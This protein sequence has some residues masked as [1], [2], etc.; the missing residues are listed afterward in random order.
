MMEILY[1]ALA[2]IVAIGI[3]VTVHEFGHFWVARRVGVRVLRFS[4]GFGR[5]LVRRVGRDGTEYVVAA[6]P[7]GGYVKMLDEREG[8]VPP[9]QLGQTFN[10]KPLWARNAV[11]VAGPMFNFMFAIVAY[12]LVFVAGTMELRPIIGTVPESTPAAAAG[13][14]AGDELISIGG[15]PTPTWQRALM[16]LLDEGVGATALPVTVVTA[17]GERETTTLN[18][19]AAGP[20]GAD[21]DVLGSLGLQPYVPT[22]APVIGEVVA[23]SPAQ[24]AGLASGD[25]ILRVDGE[26]VD[27]WSEAV[28][29]IQSRPGET[30]SIVV[31]RDG[32]QRTLTATLER[33]EAGGQV[34]G[35]LGAGPQI[36]PGLYEDLRRE[37]R[38]GPLE[39]VAQAATATW[40]LTSLTFQLLWQMAVGEASIKNLSGPLNIADFAGESA[41]LGLSQ[42]LKFLAVVSVSLGVL[43]LLPV[44]VLD[45]GHLLY[46]AI[47]WVRGRPLSEQAQ[48]VGVQIGL[49]MLFMLMS[50]AFYNDL[51]R[52]FGP[53]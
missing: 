37:V 22:I 9:E 20:L 32:Q 36:D 3:L 4:I 44:P 21:R 30:V 24:A 47:E 45:G 48:G 46:N 28:A 19:A 1:K 29:A 8:E 41:S 49:I 18:V 52:L 40:E 38:Y 5:A 34:I 12:W 6:I 2:F 26:A 42:F 11:I 10:R 53:G 35:R 43:N 7:L 16:V 33:M 14:S 17:E 31:R 50:V 25:E 27:E 51:A 39:A 15:E 23:G 13:L